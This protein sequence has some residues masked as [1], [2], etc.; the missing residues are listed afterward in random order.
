M[1]LSHNSDNNFLLISHIGLTMFISIC[2]LG[3]GIFSPLWFC[4]VGGFIPITQ[5]VLQA[6]RPG[7]VGCAGRHHAVHCGRHLFMVVNH[8]ISKVCWF[9][10]ISNEQ[11]CMC[12]LLDYGSNT[13]VF[14]F[15]VVHSYGWSALILMLRIDS[16]MANA[17]QT[18]MYMLPYNTQDSTHPVTSCL[19]KFAQT[20]EGAHNENRGF[21]KISSKYFLFVILRWLNTALHI[22]GGYIVR[23]GII[24]MLGWALGWEDQ[25]FETVDEEH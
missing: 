20:R 17:I 25:P 22:I 9:A 19:T 5:P 11:S 7:H 10:A 14:I 18:Y 6:V 3:G 4:G 15:L 21:G 12:E 24:D 23:W 16:K 1:R 2:P 13:N 8:T